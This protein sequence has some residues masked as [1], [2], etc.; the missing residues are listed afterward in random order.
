MKLE[1]ITSDPNPE[2]LKFI[3]GCVMSMGSTW[4]STTIPNL[5]AIRIQKLCSMQS[6]G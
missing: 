5:Q 2:D 1:D 3:L 6:K 4:P